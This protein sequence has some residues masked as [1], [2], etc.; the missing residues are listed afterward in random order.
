MYTLNFSIEIILQYWKNIFLKNLQEV[1]I[2][3]IFAFKQGTNLLINNFRNKSTMF[4]I[5]RIICTYIRRR[6]TKLSKI[7]RESWGK[8]RYV[9]VTPHA[10]WHNTCLWIRLQFW[11]QVK[12]F[13]AYVLGADTGYLIG[14]SLFF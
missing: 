4:H 11:W 8:L 13:P 2:S 5:F 10:G 3:K 7:L 12:S 6:T 9:R 14:Y 1:S